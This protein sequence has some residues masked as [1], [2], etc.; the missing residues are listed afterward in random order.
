MLSRK[1]QDQENSL[2]LFTEQV[3]LSNEYGIVF[4][5]SANFLLAWKVNVCFSLCLKEIKN[6]IKLHK[7]ISIA[8]FSFR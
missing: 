1:N 5:M 6:N 8:S 2:I 7:Y 4:F 3:L